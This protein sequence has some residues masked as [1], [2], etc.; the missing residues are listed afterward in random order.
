[1]K[2]LKIITLS[3]ASFLEMLFL[4]LNGIA[5]LLLMVLKWEAQ[6]LK[7]KLD[8]KQEKKKSSKI[9]EFLTV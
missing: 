4:I 1:M 9:K 6:Q 8:K 5:H 2:S 7:P 3:L